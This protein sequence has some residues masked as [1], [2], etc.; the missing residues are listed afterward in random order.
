MYLNISVFICYL[1]FFL[2]S[3]LV[4]SPA[5]YYF[6]GSRRLTEIKNLQN[7]SSSKYKERAKEHFANQEAPD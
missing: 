1:L 2:L 4:R 6:V 3:G 7:V 5:F